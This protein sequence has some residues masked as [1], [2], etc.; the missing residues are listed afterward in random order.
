MSRFHR[1][2]LPRPQTLYSHTHNAGADHIPLWA[3]PL[4]FARYGDLHL[5]IRSVAI[6]VVTRLILFL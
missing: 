1:H 4:N 6:V 3:A 2:P 5:E